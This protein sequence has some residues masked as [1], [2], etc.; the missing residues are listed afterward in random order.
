VTTALVLDGGGLPGPHEV[1]MLRPAETGV[2]PD[3]VVGT[4][5]GKVTLQLDPGPD[6]VANRP[7]STFVQPGAAER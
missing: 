7:P 1:G 5:I 6:A 2:R 4:S 3:V